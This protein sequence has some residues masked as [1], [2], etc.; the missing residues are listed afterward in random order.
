MTP[1]PPAII[2][3]T[4]ARVQVNTPFRLTPT[5]VS[6]CSSL[7]MA[8][9]APSLYLTSWPSRKTPALLT[10]TWTPPQRATTSSTAAWTPAGAGRRRIHGAHQLHRRGRGCPH[11]GHHGTAWRRIGP[12][13]GDA[14]GGVDHR[15]RQGT[16]L[17]WVAGG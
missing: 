14:G 2:F 17:R 8:V 7:I 5:T 1:P 15:V 6:N 10:S 3:G 11:D 12:S 4:T 13:V 9:S 16:G